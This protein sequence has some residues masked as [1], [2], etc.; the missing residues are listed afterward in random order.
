MG[1]I[2]PGRC[3]SWY[4]ENLIIFRYYF[5]TRDYNT[6][7]IRRVLLFNVVVEEKFMAT[8]LIINQRHANSVHFPF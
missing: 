8:D 3:L 5:I 7:N 2:N 6:S 4:Y 1:R